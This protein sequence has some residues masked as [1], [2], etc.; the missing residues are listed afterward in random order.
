MKILFLSPWFPFPPENGSKIRSYNLI[1]TL[2]KR[3]DVRL[4]SFTRARENVDLEG[5]EGICRLEAAI[6]WREFNPKSWKSLA[7]FFSPTPRS[8]IDTYNPQM[9]NQLQRSIKH[10]RPDLIVASETHTAI[11]AS[12]KWDIPCIFDTV[13]LE[14]ITQNWSTA[15]STITKLREQLTWAKGQAYVRWL[16]KKYDAC[17]VVSEREREILY[18]LIDGNKCLKVIPNGVDLD[19]NRPGITKPQ[20]YTL[21][22]P[23]ALT[24]S[25]NFDAMSYFLQDIFPLIRVKAPEATLKITGTVQ[26]VDLSRLPLDGHVE[27][28]GFLSD[29]RPAVAGA[30][31]CVVPLRQGGG[32]R[33]KILEAMALGTPVIATHKAVEGLS[34]TPEKD[35]LLADNPD[36][37]ST[38]TIR[39]LNDKRLRDELSKNGRELV[40][41]NY[42]WDAIGSSF[43]RLIESVIKNREPKEHNTA[44]RLG[45]T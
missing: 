25:A 31:A 33:L 17:T 40:V 28:S 29:I 22:Y 7:G 21:I 6:P 23:G 44:G 18:R 30:W 11:Y 13:E 8:V 39:L 16:V 9:A 34:V 32:T 5:L 15:N 12:R 27:L 20:P 10:E 45:S 42:G 26:G 38:Q 19:Y 3:H 2:S 24:F 37:F 41:N 36:E 1:K 4:I 14:L 35:I 43:D